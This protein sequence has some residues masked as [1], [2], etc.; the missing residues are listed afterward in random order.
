[1]WAWHPRL[2]V[3]LHSFSHSIRTRNT[4]A[5]RHFQVA[6]ED[7]GVVVGNFAGDDDAVGEAALALAVGEFRLALER[8]GV[9]YLDLGARGDGGGV[10]GWSRRVIRKNVR[11]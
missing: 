2:S 6:D 11:D 1:M 9:L 5:D 4:H 8:E 3:F 10:S 7:G